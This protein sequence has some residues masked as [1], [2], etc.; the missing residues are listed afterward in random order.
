MGRSVVVRWIEFVN[1][2]YGVFLPNVKIVDF[3]P[4][5]HLVQ[6]WEAAG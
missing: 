4:F 3:A 6:A 2:G 5:R 1:D